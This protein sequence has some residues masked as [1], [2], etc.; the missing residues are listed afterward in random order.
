MPTPKSR[1]FRV[2]AD[3]FDW[4]PRPGLMKCFKRGQ[5]GYEQQACITYGLSI[6]AIETIKKP[7]NAKVGKDGKIV[8][9]GN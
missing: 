8:W 7:A 9:D 6:G 2:I 3:R 5:I 1:W 4:M